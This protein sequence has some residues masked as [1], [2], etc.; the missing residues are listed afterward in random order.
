MTTTHK[1]NP[2][3]LLEHSDDDDDEGTVKTNKPKKQAPAPNKEVKSQPQANKQRVI[4]EDSAPTK[5]LENKKAP[6]KGPTQEAGAANKEQHTKPKENRKLKGVPA[7]PHPLDRKSGTGQ[8]PWDKKAKRGGGGKFNTGTVGD[9]LKAGDEPESANKEEGEGEEAEKDAGMTLAEYYQKTGQAD[10]T[11]EKVVAINENKAK[12][13]QQEL[14]KDLG[15]AKKLSNRNEVKIDDREVGPTKKIT[16]VDSHAVAMN[17]EHASLLGFK[18]GFKTYTER[19][20][21]DEQQQGDRK[22]APAQGAPTETQQPELK[23][24]NP[25]A[26]TEKGGEQQAP[27]EGGDQKQGGGYGGRGGYKGKNP[28]PSR[29]GYSSNYKGRSDNQQQKKENPPRFDDD[30]AFPKLG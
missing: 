23:E 11:E 21:F 15:T 10:Q 25:P 24:V 26:Q 28:N 17:T 4:Q 8:N 18:T 13:T 22:K 9:E 29:G 19:K 7:E 3:G 6:F 5:K 12:V 27:V 20:P 14:L 16:A 30:G 1:N 2:F